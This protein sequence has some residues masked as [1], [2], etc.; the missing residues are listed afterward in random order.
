MKVLVQENPTVYL[1]HVTLIP[2]LQSERYVSFEDKAFKLTNGTNV[3]EA[4]EKNIYYKHLYITKHFAGYVRAM[5]AG[6]DCLLVYN[7]YTNIE[8]C[9]LYVVPG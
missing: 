5:V 4:L 3:F 2:L 8:Y 7:L 1:V 6:L 9:G